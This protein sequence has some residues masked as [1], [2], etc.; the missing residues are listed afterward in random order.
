MHDDENPYA[1]D[2]QFRPPSSYADPGPTAIDTSEPTGLLFLQ[3]TYVALTTLLYLAI[4]IGA[5]V[6]YAFRFD[7][8]DD[9]D[10][11]LTEIIIMCVIYGILGAGL[12]V[13]YAVGFFWRRSMGGWIYNII[14]IVIGLTSCIT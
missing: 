9:T 3:R 8:T 10:S 13:L 1:A 12:F 2:P 7:L 6:A 5:I 14:L 4:C 11:D